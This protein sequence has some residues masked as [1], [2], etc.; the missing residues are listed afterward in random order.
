MTAITLYTIGHSNR[1][2]EEF[3]DL[4]DET[5]V[6]SLVD[7]R[8]YPHSK[9]FPHFNE[10]SL[11]QAIEQAGKVYHWVGR[12][13]GGNRQVTV[14]S[15]HVALK[16]EGLQAYADYMGTDNFQVAAM[17]LINMASHERVAVMCAERSPE[18]CH[19]SLIADY[20]VLQG[21]RV[22]HL[23]SEVEVKEHYLSGFARRE[24]SE[25]IYDRV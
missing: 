7:V 4:L 16:D 25:L 19:R 23:I 24:S 22:M 15:P 11:R 13:L 21:V 2:L 5:G 1:S 6:N 9:R 20:L 18:N 10:D 8:T 3:L 12:Q 14:G 17:Q